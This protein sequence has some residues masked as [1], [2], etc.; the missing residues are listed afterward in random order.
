L[1]QKL[2]GYALFLQLVVQGVVIW[3]NAQ[4]WFYFFIAKEHPLQGYIV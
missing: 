1:P 3:L 2:Q 4:P